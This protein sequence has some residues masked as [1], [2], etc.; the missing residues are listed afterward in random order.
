MKCEELHCLPAGLNIIYLNTKFAKADSKEH[1]GR[2]MEEFNEIWKR[3][4]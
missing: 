1:K 2:G 3:K 4:I